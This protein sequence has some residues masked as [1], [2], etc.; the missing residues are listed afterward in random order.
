M[1][2]PEQWD[3]GIDITDLKMVWKYIYT[4]DKGRKWGNMSELTGIYLLGFVHGLLFGVLI[5]FVIWIIKYNK[6]KSED[7]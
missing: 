4:Q 3:L 6:S 1:M 5:E 7:R 2:N